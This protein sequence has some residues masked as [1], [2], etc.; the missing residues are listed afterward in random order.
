MSPLTM[1]RDARRAH[2]RSTHSYCKP[3]HRNQHCTCQQ[4]KRVS[5]CAVDVLLL[6]PSQAVLFAGG[7]DTAN[8][9]CYST[10]CATSLESCANTPPPAYNATCCACGSYP[11][12]VYRWARDTGT[13][14]LSGLQTTS[15]PP[16][17]GGM[18]N[19]VCVCMCVCVC[20]H[21]SVGMYVLIRVCVVFVELLARAS[22][23]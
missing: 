17:G 19:T 9:L 1:I 13:G 16:S 12:R 20:V 18:R 2:V 3:S 21:V 8:P 5:P 23:N 15:A 10:T 4:T 14:E 7:K 11:S 6:A 22:H